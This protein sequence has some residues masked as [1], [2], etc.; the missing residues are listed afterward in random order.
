MH[1]FDRRSLLK[2]MAAASAMG[3]VPDAVTPAQAQSGLKLGC[4]NRSR[5]IC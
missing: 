2:A 5:S 1:D 3:L 4:P